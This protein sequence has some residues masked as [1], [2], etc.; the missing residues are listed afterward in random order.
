MG[1]DPAKK[2]VIGS[3][4]N[5]SS[6]TYC[7]S[8]Y[9]SHLLALLQHMALMYSFGLFKA[10]LKLHAHHACVVVFACPAALADHCR[11]CVCGF[12]CAHR[13]TDKYLVLQVAIQCTAPAA[14]LLGCAVILLQPSSNGMLNSD[15]GAAGIQMLQI[16][17]SFWQCIASFCGWWTCVS[18][19]T[20]S[21]G[22]FA[23][24]RTKLL[25]PDA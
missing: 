7:L 4:D 22:F 8:R 23:L 6:S 24:F 5:C 13:T 1:L 12:M 9:S 16:P 20:F 14:I 11:W 3:R 18:C 17:I 10:M 15:S 19:F 21:A 2:L 25:R